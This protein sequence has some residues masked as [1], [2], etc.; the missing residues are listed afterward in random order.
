MDGIF[1]NLTNIDAELTIDNKTI[2]IPANTDLVTPI[3]EVIYT[4]KM[5]NGIL[6]TPLKEDDIHY[7][8]RTNWVNTLYNKITR[9]EDDIKISIKMYS[10]YV[11]YSFTKEQI[12]KI[13]QISNGNRRTRLLILT[14]EDAQYWSD[15]KF[16]SNPFRNYRLFVNVE[17]GLIE[18]PIP[19]TYLDSVIE[20][21]KN[22]SDKIKY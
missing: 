7:L 15:G 10:P 12:E 4:N 20:G 1:I 5:I 17:K 21:V 22:L 14:K 6:S 16:E 13:N 9:S 2:I 19:K 18:Y 3:R 8:Q 11:K